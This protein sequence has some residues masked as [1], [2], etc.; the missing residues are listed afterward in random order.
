MTLTVP[1]FLKAYGFTLILLFSVLLGSLAGFIMG[2]DAVILKPFGDVFL[3]LMFTIVVPLVFFSISSAVA[4]M[5]DRKRLRKIVAWMILIFVI[6]GIIASILMI[7]GVR[8]YPPAEGIVLDLSQAAPAESFNASERIVRAFT[9][10]DFYELLSKK[11]MLALIVF[12]VLVGLGAS[13]LDK[14]GEP[15]VNF[16]SSTNEVMMK[17]IHYVMYYAPVGLGAY[18]AYLTGVFGP[19]LLSTY[20]RAVSL[21]YP[22]SFLYFFLF[23]SL[24][25]YFA[26]KMPGVKTFWK[27]IIPPSLTALATGSSMA[28]IP[29]NLE[30]AEKTG[31]PKDISEIVIP[32]GATIHMDGSCLSAILKIALLFGLFNRDF[33]GFETIITAIGIAILSGSVMSGIPGGGF[34]GEFLIVSLYGFPIESLP[35][36]SMVGILVDPPATM[37]NAVGDNVVSMMVAR[38]VKRKEKIHEMIS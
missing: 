30:A 7:A 27:N 32:V 2:E 23:F 9:V 21:Y 6:T 5:K 15:F 3:N 10:S 35:I 4:G 28:T 38:L 33:T 26:G 13:S 17:V 22:L 11:N 36:I 37:V 24:Y 31:I 20:A 19:K 29:S 18:F 16:L 34:I 14:K 25:A 1:S 8:C 12:S